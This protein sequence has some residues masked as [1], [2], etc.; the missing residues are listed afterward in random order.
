M[1]GPRLVTS[2]F[3]HDPLIGYRPD[4][5]WEAIFRIVT[6]NATSD[7]FEKPPLRFGVFYYSRS[8]T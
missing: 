8:I 4:I 5:L 6:D 2:S 7:T 3:E 1:V